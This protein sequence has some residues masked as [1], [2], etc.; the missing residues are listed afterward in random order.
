MGNLMV[1]HGV[2]VPMLTPFSA[3]G[4]IDIGAARRMARRLADAGAFVFVLGTTGEG[5]SIS[6]AKREQLVKAVLDELGKGAVIYAGIPSNC[7][8]DQIEM[9]NRYLELGVPA[10]VAHL[11]CYYPLSSKEML[12]YFER[13]ADAI[14]GSVV[15]YNIPQTV[16]QSLPLE[17]VEKL[18]KR[19]NIV[20]LK[21]TEKNQRRL[22]R[23]LSFWARREDFAYLIGHTPFAVTGLFL[24]ANGWVPTVGNL[25][26]DLCR[27]LYD[28]A[29]RGERDKA[30]QA[31]REIEQVRA[32]CRSVA[33]FKYGAS[34][35]GLCSERVLPPL[36]GVDDERKRRIKER[37][38]KAGMVS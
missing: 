18:S 20:A 25:V 3:D 29:G 9:G 8:E 22:H 11:P 31:C 4:A 15:L 37:L 21:D 36:L 2:I 35:M 34:L 19:E 1:S 33:E 5:F 7:L 24:G 6:A 23:A 13:L 38:V 12:R 16:G 32:I 28:C 26:P 14:D 27:R 30:E 10:V 17:V